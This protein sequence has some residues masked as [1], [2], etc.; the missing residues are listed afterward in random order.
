MS[1]SFFKTFI[2]TQVWLDLMGVK[3]Y[4]IHDDLT[5]DVNGSVDISFE[6]LTCIPVQFGVVKGD[7]NCYFNHLTTLIGAPNT[8]EW[9]LCY[10]N[11]LTSLDGA[12]KECTT[13]DCSGNRLTD[14]AGMPLDCKTV[15]CTENPYLRDIN[16]APD[17]CK[18]LYQRDVVEKNQSARQMDELVC[19]NARRDA[20]KSK[21]G[22]ML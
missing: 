5:V 6:G 1:D 17:G 19:E 7:F 21:S 2:E 9:F 8:C 11:H 18:V 15:D 13:F 20:L 10:G 12:P 3:N 16:M 4:T 14:L 22:R